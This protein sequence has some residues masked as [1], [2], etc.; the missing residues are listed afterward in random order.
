M[1]KL[2]QIKKLVLKQETVRML[3]RHQLS[4]IAGGLVTVDTDGQVCPDFTQV[5]C[6]TLNTACCVSET[7]CTQTP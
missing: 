1:K 5:G 7:Q 3:S 4:G 2:A 6:P